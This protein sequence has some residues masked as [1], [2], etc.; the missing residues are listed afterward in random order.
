MVENLKVIAEDICRWGSSDRSKLPNRVVFLQKQLLHL[1]VL[2]RTFLEPS[3][4][5]FEDNLTP[6][7]FKFDSVRKGIEKNLPE[8]GYYHKV[9]N[10]LNIS[11]DPKIGTADAVD[12]LTDII[13]DLTEFIWRANNSSEIEAIWHFKFNF[14]AHTNDHL[15]GL[16]NYL[17]VDK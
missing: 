3:F 16:L 10:P 9:L 7:D 17:G 11:E 6:P 14:R 8:L 2:E 4:E 13:K 15:I 1:Y 5:E 12:D